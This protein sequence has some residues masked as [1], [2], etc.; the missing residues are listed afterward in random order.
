MENL[1][2]LYA[3][4]LL[5]PKAN[6]SRVGDMLAGEIPAVVRE[7]VERAKL[8]ALGLQSIKGGVLVLTEDALLDSAHTMQMQ[9]RLLNRSSEVSPTELEQF[10]S[11]FGKAAGEGLKGLAV[12]IGRGS[13]GQVYDANVDEV[14]GEMPA[15]DSRAQRTLA[16]A[17]EPNHKR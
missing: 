5:E 7:V 3:R 16:L 1:I 9:I 11:A 15:I 10:G 17:A 12:L 13:N 8:S 6:L 4:G 14:T 2:R